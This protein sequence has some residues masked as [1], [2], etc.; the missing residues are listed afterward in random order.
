MSYL[1]PSA[2]EQPKESKPAAA[3]YPMGYAQSETLVS[4]VPAPKPISTQSF[5]HNT[6]VQQKKTCEVLREE[7]PELFS[8]K[9]VIVKSVANE[10]QYKQEQQFKSQSSVESLCD[11]ME[12]TNTVMKCQFIRPGFNASNTV[13]MCTSDMLRE[14][15]KTEADDFN[16]KKVRLN[17]SS[18]KGLMTPEH[19]TMFLSIMQTKSGNHTFYSLDYHVAEHKDDKLFSQY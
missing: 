17:L 8:E 4:L 2:R 3:Q 16:L 10:R 19:G 9:A 13:L 6:H 11:V 18:D 15:I 14:A 12:K 1:K 5:D 7:D